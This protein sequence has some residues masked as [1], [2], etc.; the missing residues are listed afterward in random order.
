MTV[1]T[2]NLGAGVT[3]L[4]VAAIYGG[5]ALQTLPLGTLTNMGPGLFPAALCT[6]LAGLGAILVITSLFQGRERA[7]EVIAWRALLT[8]SAGILFFGIFIQEA[9]LALAVFVTATICSL[10]AVETRP[11]VAAA[12]GVVMS[13]F[14][15]AVFIYA[16]RLPMPVV[17]SW[18]TG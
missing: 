2:K 4:A 13:V 10:A 16:L 1:N 5:T 17:G 9:G 8:V 18:F 6:I 3:F 12:I 14:C 7:F 11:L 15:V